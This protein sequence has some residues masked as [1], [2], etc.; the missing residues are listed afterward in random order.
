MKQIFGLIILI[1]IIS[2]CEMIGQSC[3]KYYHNNDSQYQYYFYALVLYAVVCRLL[4]KTYDHQ[5][6]GLVNVLW[7]GISI[8]FGLFAGAI[9]FKEQVSYLDKI[10]IVCV[11]LGISLI[12]YKG[13]HSVDYHK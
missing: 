7:S 8:L 4:V 10:G 1:I 6:M 12:M 13:K 9:F 5:G 2:M 11:I 3:L